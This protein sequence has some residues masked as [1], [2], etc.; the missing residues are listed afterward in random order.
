MNCERA[1]DFFSEYHEGTLS[2]GL[3]TTF[4][5]HLNE[6]PACSYE[7]DLFRK[8][9]E[10][11]SKPIPVEVPGDLLEKITRSLDKAEWQKKQATKPVFTWMRV[12]AY[13]A[14]AAAFLAVAYFGSYLWQHEKGGIQA[15]IVPSVRSP[16]PNIEVLDGEIR[17]RYKPNE[18]TV[19]T[20]FSGGYHWESLPPSDAKRIDTI[21]LNPGQECDTP[22][23]FRGDSTAMIWVQESNVPETLLIIVPGQSSSN[24]GDDR[25]LV[26][27]LRTIAEKFGVIIQARLTS[28]DIQVEPLGDNANPLEATK[29]A[30]E[31]TGLRVKAQKGFLDIR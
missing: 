5:R 16:E 10:T 4:E 28:G 21:R 17:L 2:G 18:A 12:G 13:A 22:L 3:R 31:G 24:G 23:V 6:C 15:G 26:P 25:R 8:V 9:Y 14:T 19:L 30:L 27:I 20:V 1:K 11:A 7:L 29:G